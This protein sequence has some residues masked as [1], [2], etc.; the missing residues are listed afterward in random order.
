MN[1]NAVAGD[2]SASIA[3]ELNQPLGA[4]LAHAG[5]AKLILRSASPNLQ[6]VQDIIADIARDDLRASEIIKRLRNFLTKTASEWR[7]VDLNDVVRE[8]LKLLAD[9]AESSQV[10]LNSLLAPQALRVHGDPV[11]LQT[12]RRKSACEC[13]G[14]HENWRAREA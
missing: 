13:N 9:Q 5:T 3:H 14:V 8:V 1:R 11:Q 6:E 10:R 7:D 2:M 12:G 4:I